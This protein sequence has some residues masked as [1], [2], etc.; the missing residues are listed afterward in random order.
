MCNSPQL[1]YVGG[2]FPATDIVSSLDTRIIILLQ[3]AA[4]IAE[5]MQIALKS[6][7]ALKIL[8]LIQLIQSI[9]IMLSQY[10]EL[11]TEQENLIS[12]N[13]RKFSK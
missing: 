4:W 1:E 9:F 13:F 10:S 8:M 6:M 12:N 2:A 11:W 7:K 3:N 5:G